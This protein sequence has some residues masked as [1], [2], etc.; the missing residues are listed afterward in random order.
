M[1]IKIPKIIIDREDCLPTR[2]FNLH[3]KEH[4]GLTKWYRGYF[5][6]IS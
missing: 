3:K 5:D 1:S 4:M 6:F 2:M